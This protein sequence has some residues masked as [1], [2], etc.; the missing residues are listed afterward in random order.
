MAD[1]NPKRL[2]EVTIDNFPVSVR[3][4]VTIG[5][6]V[7]DEVKSITTFDPKTGR[8]GV[9]RREHFARSAPEHFTT[10]LTPIEKGGE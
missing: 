6:L 4:D 10:D 8:S 3:E 2:K 5:E 7:D 1:F 9:I